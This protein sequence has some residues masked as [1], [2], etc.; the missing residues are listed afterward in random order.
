MTSAAGGTTPRLPTMA[1][2]PAPTGP[3]SPGSDAVKIATS[4][5]P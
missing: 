2:G 3:V 5:T 1:I 4:G